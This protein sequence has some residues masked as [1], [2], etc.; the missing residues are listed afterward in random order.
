M[1]HATLILFLLLTGCAISEEKEVAMGRDAAPKFE[2][3]FGGLYPDPAVQEYV[4]GVGI[5]LAQDTNRAHLPWQFR[6]LNSDDVN[7]FAL[8][9]GFVYITKG[10]LFNLEN[11]AQ[12][13]S[14]LGH[15]VAHVAHRHSVQQL[16]RAQFVQGGSLLVGI[17]AGGTAGDVSSLAA[18]LALMRYGRGQEREADLSG[19]NYVVREGYEP[20]AMVQTMEI[21]ERTSGGKRGGLGFLSTHPSPGNREKYLAERISKR[22]ETDASGGVTNEDRFESIVLRHR[23]AIGQR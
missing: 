3:E 12:L 17:F 22:Y 18:S 13:A 14:V 4:H 7:A 19:L 15:E 2:R 10:L 5:E 1:R 8:P 11:E 9:G 20:R 23:D 6:V 16:Q 21:L